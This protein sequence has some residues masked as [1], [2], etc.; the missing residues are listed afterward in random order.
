MG[1]RVVARARVW[2]RA[3]GRVGGLSWGWDTGSEPLPGS[4]STWSTAWHTEPSE[5]MT[6]RKVLAMATRLGLGL[7]QGSVRVRVG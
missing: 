2:G 5:E 3:R 4:G 7:G 6:R 1:N